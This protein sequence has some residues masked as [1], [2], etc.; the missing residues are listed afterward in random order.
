[1]YV[2]LSVCP[3]SHAGSAKLNERAEPVPRWVHAKYGRVG[4]QPL[5]RREEAA[6]EEASQTS[7][8]LCN[9]RRGEKSK[10]VAWGDHAC[11]CTYA[12]KVRTTNYGIMTNCHHF[13]VLLYT[14][15]KLISCLHSHGLPML[16]FMIVVIKTIS[17]C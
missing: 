5:W 7:A 15:V 13:M 9:G 12:C 11:M 17:Q 4:H 16:L 10:E 8:C 14:I 1:M 2:C 6:A 3:S